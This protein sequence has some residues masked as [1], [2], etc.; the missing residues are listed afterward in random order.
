M[1]RWALIFL[2][3]AIVAGVL[4][5]TDVQIV[6]ATIARVLFGI[7]L[8]GFLMILLFGFALGSWLTPR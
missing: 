5:F 1:L 6:S 2:L 8:F 7:F 3:I 4:G